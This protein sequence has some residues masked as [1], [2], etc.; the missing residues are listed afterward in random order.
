MRCT[1]S[2]S[3]PPSQ[4]SIAECLQPL[5]RHVAQRHIVETDAE[6]AR[7]AERPEPACEP[8]CPDAV[9]T[10]ANRKRSFL[11]RGVSW[12]LGYVDIAKAQEL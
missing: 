11:D 4:D 12:V 9:A 3:G 1:L 5:K 8:P 10:R 7:V 2:R 6:G